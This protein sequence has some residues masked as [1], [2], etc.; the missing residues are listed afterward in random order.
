MIRDRLQDLEKPERRFVHASLE[1]ELLHEMRIAGK[2]L[3]YAIELFAEGWDPKILK[4]REAR[5]TTTVYFRTG[6]RFAISG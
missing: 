4:H 5:R 2:R 1:S 3:R 6:A